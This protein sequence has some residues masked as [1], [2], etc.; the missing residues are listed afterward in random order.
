MPD[1]VQDLLYFTYQRLPTTFMSDVESGFTSSN[2]NLADNIIEGD[3][4]TGL[5][6]KSKREIQLIMRARGVTFDEARAIYTQRTFKKAGIGADGLPND[7]KLVT[8]GSR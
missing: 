2:F 7:P 3:S 5:D 4:R 8:F 1:R 6:A